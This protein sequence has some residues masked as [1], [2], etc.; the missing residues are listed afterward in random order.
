MNTFH[1]VERTEIPDRIITFS[2]HIVLKEMLNLFSYL[3]GHS[4]NTRTVQK[5]KFSIKDFFSKYDQIHSFLRIWSNLLKKS[6]TEN[7]I[8]RAVLE[9]GHIAVLLLSTKF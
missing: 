5:M 3:L 4:L 7:V 8:F 9:R 2:P 1:A 6:L